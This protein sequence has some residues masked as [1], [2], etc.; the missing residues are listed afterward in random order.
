[1]SEEFDASQVWD[2]PVSADVVAAHDRT[3][4]H[5]TQMPNAMAN[6]RLHAANE[7]Q[8]IINVCNRLAWRAV[9]ADLRKPGA[10]EAAALLDRLPP[11]DREKL[12]RE[13]QLGAAQRLLLARMDE[14]Q[15][16]YQAQLRAAEEEAERQKREAAEWAE[17]EAYDAAGKEARFQAW[18]AA[19][20]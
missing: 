3:M 13:S 15:A 6:A 11:E 10:E 19:R 20:G 8:R 4:T 9:P 7:L 14:A 12:L 16:A 2:E 17:F 5:L 1:M 18:R